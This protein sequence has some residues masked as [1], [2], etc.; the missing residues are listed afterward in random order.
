[1]FLK[2]LLLALFI[3][4]TGELA[5]LGMYALGE[6]KIFVA[7][8]MMGSIMTKKALKKCSKSAK[9]QI[10]ATL[11]SYPDVTAFGRV[12]WRI[13]CTVLA[14]TARVSLLPRTCPKRVRNRALV[15]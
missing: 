8:E 4:A 2:W 13:D 14:V 12:L 7:T 5:V 1:M 9:A 10:V 15:S 6:N 11:V 3:Q